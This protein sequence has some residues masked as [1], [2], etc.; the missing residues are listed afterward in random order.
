LFFYARFLSQLFT[1]QKLSRTVFDKIIT[2]K[3]MNRSS[4]SGCF[5]ALSKSAKTENDFVG[6]DFVE[7]LWLRLCRARFFVAIE[8]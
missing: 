4:L 7:I 8:P 6:N 2:D 5:R 1:H 3:I